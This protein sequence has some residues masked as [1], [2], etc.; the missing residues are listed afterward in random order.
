MCV[1]SPFLP[2]SQEYVVSVDFFSELY[3]YLKKSDSGNKHQ[4]FTESN[5]LIGFLYDG[6]YCGLDGPY[7]IEQPEN[8]NLKIIDPFLCII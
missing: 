5:K 2:R 4:D 7:T 3:N 6:I 8:P 1:I